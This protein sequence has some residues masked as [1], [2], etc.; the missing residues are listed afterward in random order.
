MIAVENQ[1]IEWL[2]SVYFPQLWS[3]IALVKLMFPLFNDAY[4]YVYPILLKV[5]IKVDK[6][7]NGIFLAALSRLNGASYA[8]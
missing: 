3:F 5:R 2:N 7:R 6:F 8:T 4:R 1:T